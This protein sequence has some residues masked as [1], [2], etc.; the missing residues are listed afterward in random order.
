MYIPRIHI[1]I[2]QDNPNLF[3]TVIIQIYTPT[4]N[5]Y[6]LL[7]MH[8]FLNAWY[9]SFQSMLSNCVILSA[10]M[11]KNTPANTGGVRDMGSIPG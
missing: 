11:V 4:I 8:F 2:S 9:T 7:F 5:A 3:S 1:L 10:L 6:K